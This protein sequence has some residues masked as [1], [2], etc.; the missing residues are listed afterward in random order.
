[1]DLGLDLGVDLG[2]LPASRS[3]SVLSSSYLFPLRPHPLHEHRTRRLQHPVP[4]PPGT[5]DRV[6]L[7][8]M[9]SIFIGGLLEPIPPPPGTCDR[10]QLCAMVSHFIGG[11]LEPVPPPPW[12]CDRVQLCVMVSIFTVSNEVGER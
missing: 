7:C 12:T 8:V 9:V 11:L 2:G 4:P 3:S 10:V 6:Q 5:C 1:M